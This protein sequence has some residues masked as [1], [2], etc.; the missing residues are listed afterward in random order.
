MA[1]KQEEKRDM[2]ME[3]YLLAQLDQP[4]LLKDGCPNS[5]PICGICA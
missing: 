2:T 5:K 1:K 4:V 3:E